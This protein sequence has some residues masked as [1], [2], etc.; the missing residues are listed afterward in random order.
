[1]TVVTVPGSI[2]HPPLRV[3]GATT[4]MILCW[5]ASPHDDDVRPLNLN[6]DWLQSTNDRWHAW[7]IH[8][9]IH[10][11][12][13]RRVQHAQTCLTYASLLI[14]SAPIADTFSRGAGDDNRYNKT[15]QQQMVEHS[16]HA[17]HVMQANY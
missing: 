6:L 16:S 9:N 3:T 7:V 1:M 15:C 17:M 5:C 10:L 11:V 2:Q 13:Q 4:Q 8:C 12:R 14:W